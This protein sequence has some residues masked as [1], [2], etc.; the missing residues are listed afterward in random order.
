MK[1]TG[2]PPTVEFAGPVAVAEK[3]PELVF[4]QVQVTAPAA[5][6]TWPTVFAQLMPGVPETGGVGGT[7]VVGVAVRVGVFVTVGVNVTVGVAVGA[8][9]LTVTCEQERVPAASTAIQA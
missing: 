8:T 9:M 6:Q 3:T 7:P 4:V 1:I 5:L 2:T